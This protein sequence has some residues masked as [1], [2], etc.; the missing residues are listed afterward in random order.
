MTTPWTNQ[1]VSLI[2]LTEQTSGFSGIFGYSPTVGAGNLI[3]SISADAGTD[4]YGNSYPA[5][6][7]A[8]EGLGIQTYTQGTAPAGTIVTGSIWVN[9]SAGNSIY[10]WSGS[11]WVPYTLGTAAITPG[12]VTATLLSAGI[13]VAGIVNGTTITGGSLI[14][15]GSNGG[16]FVYSGV[17]ASGNLIGSW[18]GQAGTDGEGNSYP[19]GLNVTVGAISGTIIDSSTF[20]GTEFILNTSGAFFYSGTPGFG[21][22]IVSV[23]PSDGTDGFGNSYLHGVQV[24]NNSAGVGSWLHDGAISVGPLS[25]LANYA[26]YSAPGI[27]NNAG[28]SGRVSMFSGQQNSTDNQA[29]ITCESEGLSGDTTGLILLA[30]GAVSLQGNA[31][32]TIPQ[33]RPPDYPLSD[34]P[35]SGSLWASLERANY[36]NKPIDTLNA[37]IGTLINVGIL[38]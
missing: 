3:F 27:S 30:A 20:N 33:P 17:P 8:V 35:N 15:D 5:G 31:G 12:S 2:I 9:T 26:S 25:D 16:V 37:L 23:A 1:A 11:A 28:V 14:A 34:D 19:Q 29:F 36:I 32:T 6:L 38:S 10:I 4:P 7:S 18:A 24:F 13:I 21:N 22:L